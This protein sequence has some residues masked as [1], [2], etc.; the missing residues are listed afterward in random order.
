MSELAET[1]TKASLFVPK[2]KDDGSNWYNFRNR[3]LDYI[4]GHDG[5]R[6]HLMGRVKPPAALSDADMKDPAKVDAYEDQMDAFLKKESAIRSIILGSVPERIQN[7]IISATRA[8]ELWLQ[9]SK[10]FENQNAVIQARLLSELHRIR[11]PEGGNTLKTIE[12]VLSKSN[13]YSAAGGTLSEQ[14][15]GAI[16]I[17]AVPAKFHPV[18][19]TVMTNASILN[20]PIS[21]PSLI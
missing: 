14:D 10:L 2:L 7:R 6:K 9:L 19:Q 4:Y 18:I 16:L 17:N 8:S 12:E 20:V 21:L 5:Y 11:T 15:V 13:N 1:V 3:I